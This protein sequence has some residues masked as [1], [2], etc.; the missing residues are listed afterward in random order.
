[1]G[2]HIYEMAKDRVRLSQ[3][4]SWLLR[5]NAEK[6][7]FVFLEGG[8]LPVQEVLKHKR[9]RGG[10]YTLED[11]QA[12]V[13]EC[14]KQR[15]SLKTSQEGHSISTVEVDLEEVVDP[16]QTP[17]V[18]HGTYLRNWDAIKA[19]GL[20][21]MTRNHIHF[22]AGEPGQDGVISGMRKTADLKIYM[23]MSKAMAAGL[24]FFRSANN[25]ILSP[26]DSNG[27]IQPEFFSK[28]KNVKTNQIIF[29]AENQN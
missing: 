5:H 17:V 27:I 24:R 10:G 1:M 20:S 2:N 23:D 12:V 3:A 25:V 7:G 21:R 29:S 15:F 6:E 9:F 11:V 4:L 8:F 26:G 13:A 28:V 22:S 16:S 18:I 14:P 19:G